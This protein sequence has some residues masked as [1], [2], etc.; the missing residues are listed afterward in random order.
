M[1]DWGILELGYQSENWFAI[2]LSREIVRLIQTFLG[3]RISE[4]GLLGYIDPDN[5][6]LQ[7]WPL[8]P[9]EG[10]YW[11]QP[12]DQPNQW[13]LVDDDIE[14]APSMEVDG[15]IIANC[16]IQ[17]SGGR[18]IKV[19]AC[20]RCYFV[21][22]RSGTAHVRYTRGGNSHRNLLWAWDKVLAYLDT[23]GREVHDAYEEPNYGPVHSG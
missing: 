5:S 8:I 2:A 13:F 17:L 15:P 18:T 16:L 4:E 23:T 19:D 7:W 1:S 22:K 3:D 11:L 20:N 12:R 9:P 10:Q 6:W 14:T 21:R